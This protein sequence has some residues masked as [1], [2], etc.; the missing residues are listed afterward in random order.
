M[1]DIYRIIILPEAANHLEE[2]HGYIERDSPQNAV[3]VL[4]KILA[5][6]DSLDRFP[7]RYK[8]H[9]SNKNPD[10]VVHSMPV[11]PLIIYYR[12]IERHQVV[13]VMTIRH[14]ARR[15]PPRFR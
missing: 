11:P 6:I 3:T 7:H 1:A 4:R 2:I 14:G 12:I 8:V 15:Q 5:A 13:E 10:R 9:V